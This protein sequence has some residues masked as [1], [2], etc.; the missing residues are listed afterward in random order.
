MIWSALRK[1]GAKEV[2]KMP[3]DTLNRMI[4]YVVEHAMEAEPE[5]RSSFFANSSDVLDGQECCCQRGAN[6]RDRYYPVSFFLLSD[7]DRYPARF[8][9][10]FRFHFHANSSDYLQFPLFS[11]F[12]ILSS[13]V[14]A[15]A[16]NV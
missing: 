15:R 4:P 16:E 11:V 8:R 14:K 1:S 7:F 2:Q 5:M 12:T 6:T 13:P 10:K 3:Q 9:F